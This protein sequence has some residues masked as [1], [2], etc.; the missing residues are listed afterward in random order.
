M[1]A[2]ADVRGSVAGLVAGRAALGQG[3]LD[4]FFAFFA[5]PRAPCAV[6]ARA[7]LGGALAFPAFDPPAL[8]WDGRQR[9][10]DRLARFFAV[11]A[12]ADGHHRDLGEAGPSGGDDG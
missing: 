9:P 12:A 2:T 3:R 7:A 5:L 4:H 1:A 10:E 8:V 6:D 11:Y